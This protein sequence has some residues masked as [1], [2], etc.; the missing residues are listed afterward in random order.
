[1]RDVLNSY[2]WR[3]KRAVLRCAMCAHAKPC[4]RWRQLLANVRRCGLWRTGC[5]MCVQE[6]LAHV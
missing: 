2:A 1:M 5:A 3:A 4:T 6:I